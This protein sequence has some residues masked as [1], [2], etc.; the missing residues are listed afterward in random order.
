MAASRTRIGK[1]AALIIA[2]QNH[3]KRITDEQAYA[4]ASAC[5]LQLR[6]HVAPAW[7]RI[8]PSVGFAPAKG[9]PPEASRVIL[10]VDDPDVPNVLGYHD[11]DA[12]GHPYGR[13]F[14]APTLDNGGSI[15]TSSN[16]ISV[17]TSHEACELFGDA[18]ANYWADAPDGKSYAL[19]LGDA[20]EGDS[21][22]IPVHGTLVSVSNFLL[23]AWFEKVPEE[24]RRFDYLGKL[25][26]PFTMDAGGY[27]I[28][29]KGGAVE[30]VFAE[31]YPIWKKELRTYGPSPRRAA[32][33]K[34]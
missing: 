23:P 28:F 32:R 29:F 5:D 24:G 13:V 4:I 10:L 8:P 27:M 25:T 12:N 26:A 33:W 20:C 7:G 14:V 17:T 16:S 18:S 11:V 1:G 34:A 19:E 30:E 9:Q 2:L 22:P 21:Y 6:L 15:L 3:S 31:R